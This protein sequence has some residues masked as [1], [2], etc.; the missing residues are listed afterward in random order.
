MKRKNILYLLLGTVTF[1]GLVGYNYLVAQ[2]KIKETRPSP[3]GISFVSFPEKV[4]LGQAGT[5]IWSIDSS[6]DLSTSQTTIYWGYTA[7]PSALTKVDSPD[8]V[9]YANHQQDYQMGIFKLP[10]TFDLSISFPKSGKIFFR[11]YAKVGESHLWTEEK[12]V[13]VTVNQKDVNQ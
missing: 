4:S 5:F 3:L 1:I 12:S 6:P 11:A 13:T 2:R 8:A 9:G 10:D 7:S